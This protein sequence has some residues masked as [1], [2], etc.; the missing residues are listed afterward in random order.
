MRE[1]SVRPGREGVDDSVV[2]PLTQ[3]E[4]LGPEQAAPIRAEL[5]LRHADIAAALRDGLVASLQRKY[6]ARFSH[7]DRH[8]I[9]L[10]QDIRPGPRTGL[11]QVPADSP[12]RATDAASPGRSLAETLDLDSMDLVALSTDAASLFNIFDV[13]LEDL[14]L[15]K[16]TLADW[17][18]VVLLARSK[19][20][21]GF[22]FA[23][24]GSTGA[25]KRFRHE[26]AWLAQEVL[27]WQALLPVLGFSPKR[28][29]VC[30][31]RCHIYGFIWGVV[32]PAMLDLPVLDLSATL[33]QPS[34]FEPS[35]WIIAA[36]PQWRAWSERVQLGARWPTGTWGV[37]STAPLAD[38]TANALAPHVPVLQIYGSSET[39]G[40]AWRTQPGPWSWAAHWHISESAATALRHCPDGQWRAFTLPD[41]VTRLPQ[42]ALASA[43]ARQFYLGERSDCAVQV[44]GHNVLPDWVADQ[45]RGV[46]GVADLC[47]RLDLG[48][49]EPRLKAF[50]V[51]HAQA[52]P[53]QVLGALSLQSQLL[54]AHARPMRW[55]FGAS[56]PTNALGKPTDW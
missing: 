49:A 6:P 2:T 31:P 18:D 1:P 48:S 14:L 38:E 36:P 30:V 25:P 39:A 19:G 4:D 27:A 24:S 11:G 13:G 37:S 3:G 12:A 42:N 32:L 21:S 17:A 7:L 46:E 23:S 28:V 41:V 35:D 9:A 15:A 54:P 52:D 40:L 22:T 5:T 50:V 10:N 45:L 43:S 33:A 51:C 34:Q 8:N 56:L 29:V 16:R 44:L 47:V 20:A 26:D 55:T 53:A